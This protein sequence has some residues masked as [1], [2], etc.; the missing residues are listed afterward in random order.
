MLSEEAVEI[1]G[2]FNVQVEELYELIPQFGKKHARDG[3]YI[4]R[5]AKKESKKN[6]THIDYR[7][8]QDSRISTP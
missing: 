3:K 5:F 4:D 6:Q 7:T 1:A 8:E 2:I